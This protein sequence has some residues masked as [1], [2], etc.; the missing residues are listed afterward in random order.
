MWEAIQ[1]NKRKSVLLIIV[2][3]FILLALGA[4]IGGSFNG[5]QEGIFGGVAI[6]GILN[7]SSFR[8]AAESVRVRFEKTTGKRSAVSRREEDA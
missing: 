4:S 3:G 6:A 8:A 2:M 5:S 1:R 7:R